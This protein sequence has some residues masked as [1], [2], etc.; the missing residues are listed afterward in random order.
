MSDEK[1]GFEEIKTVP[2]NPNDVFRCNG[3]SLA[4]RLIDFWAWNQSDLVENRNRG[5]LAEFLVRQALELDYPTRLEWDAFDLITEEGL[6]IEIKS[7]AYIQ[8]W[9]QKDY[10]SISFDIKPTKTLLADNNY[11]RETTRHADLYVFCLLH[12]RDKAT[13][14]PLDLDQWTFYITTTKTLNEKLPEQKSIR[15]STIETIPHEKCSFS[16]L[17]E[18]VE[19]LK[20][21]ISIERLGR[22]GIIGQ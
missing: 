11:S 12:H 20:S 14:D 6:K 3:H 8:S 1:M 7:A 19:K 4:F 18:R 15:I 22:E 2:R 13:I 10:S 16:E 5:I 9:K 17:K 21:N